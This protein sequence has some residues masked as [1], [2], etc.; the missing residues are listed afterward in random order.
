MLA[1]NPKPLHEHKVQSQGKKVKKKKV[2]KR[3]RKVNKPLYVL[4]SIIC[5]GISLVLLSRYA[6]ITS[7]RENIT[8]LEIEKEELIKEKVN[9]Q[10][11]LEGIKSSEK[12]IDDARYKLGMYP[13]EEDQIIYI[14]VDFSEENGKTKESKTRDLGYFEKFR[15]FF[16]R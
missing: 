12:V 1:R 15:D 5:L 13:P 3:G 16:R 6:K 14:D 8:E 11:K 7:I 2:Q 10:A 4:V 9:L